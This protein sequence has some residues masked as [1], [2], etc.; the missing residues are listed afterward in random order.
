MHS[1]IQTELSKL[2]SKV[3]QLKNYMFLVKVMPSASTMNGKESGPR[4]KLPMW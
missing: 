4:K 2:G 1:Y 3:L